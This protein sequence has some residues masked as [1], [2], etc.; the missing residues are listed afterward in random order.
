MSNIHNAHGLLT[1]L[2]DLS[3][4]HKSHKAGSGVPV[5]SVDDVWGIKVIEEPVSAASSED[6]EE[7]RRLE[8]REKRLA[9][10]HRLQVLEFMLE[11]SAHAEH[12][13][14]S[15]GRL[16]HEPLVK[17]EDIQPLE[18]SLSNISLSNFSF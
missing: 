4:R 10:G 2:E 7:E 11:H 14:R 18:P 8:A 16:A 9:L 12:S 1:S 13:L 3:S 5:H 6:C 15:T 17:K